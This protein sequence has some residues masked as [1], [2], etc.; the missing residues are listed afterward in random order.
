MA[1]AQNGFGGP[2]LRGILLADAQSPQLMNAARA[3]RS[4]SFSV[5]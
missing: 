1:D 2:P 3:R 4:Q 5:A